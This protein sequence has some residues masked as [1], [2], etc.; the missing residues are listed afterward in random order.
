MAIVKASGT[1]GVGHRR[2]GIVVN[3]DGAAGAA[4][5]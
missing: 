5:D 2:F 4:V 3:Q 1:G